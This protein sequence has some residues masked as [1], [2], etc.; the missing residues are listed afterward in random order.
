MPD[1]KYYH[2]RGC[3]YFNLQEFLT[4]VND[5]D[6]AEVLDENYFDIN[7]FYE[8][9]ISEILDK[10]DEAIIQYEIFQRIKNTDFTCTLI[11]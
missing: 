3:N 6:S 1:S 2:L 10:Y 7:I 5:F 11:C 8:A 9:Q 4:A